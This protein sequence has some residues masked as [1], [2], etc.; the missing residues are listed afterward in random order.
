MK[1]INSITIVSF[2]VFPSPRSSYRSIVYPLN[3]SVNLELYVN[4]IPSS[5]SLSLSVYF[6]VLPSISERTV[7][8]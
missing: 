2:T 1:R 5:L 3:T 4:S 6:R 8:N 7:V